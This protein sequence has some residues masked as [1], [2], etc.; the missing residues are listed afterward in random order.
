MT[1]KDADDSSDQSQ[2][3][4]QHQDKAKRKARAGDGQVQP[5]EQVQ[6]DTG[7]ALSAAQQ[8]A[9]VA[10]SSKRSNALWFVLAMVAIGLVLASSWWGEHSTT[11]KQ[12]SNSASM[13]NGADSKAE[14]AA[15]E[16][17]LKRLQQEG[18]HLVHEFAQSTSSQSQNPHLLA[19]QNAPTRM[20]LATLPS[21]NGVGTQ[22]GPFAGTSV[23]DHFGNQASNTVSIE[24]KRMAHPSYTIASGEL[25]H[26][27]LETAL[28]SDLPGMVR[29]ELT[30]PVYAYTGQRTLIP[31]GSRLIGQYSSAVFQGHSRVMIVWNRVILPKGIVIRINSPG[32]DDL[33]RAGMGADHVNRHFVERFG[34]ATLLSLIG[35]GVANAGVATNDQYNSKATYRSAIAQS[36]QQSANQSLQNNLP[37][38]PTITIHQG[39]KINVFVAR[40]LSFYQAL[41]HMPQQ[42]G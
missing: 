12:T 23:Y 35:A 40:D 9:K 34:E 3:E 11:S 41:Q 36:F 28:N 20:Y 4:S 2:D 27:V 24:A 32:T 30:R 37:I 5:D 10:N 6:P 22:A 29:A 13:A 16:A 19:R 14:L 21:Q 15:N 39:A 42:N 31:A 7:D 17:T 8:T 26:A 38:K 18:K 25:L 33:G 1:I